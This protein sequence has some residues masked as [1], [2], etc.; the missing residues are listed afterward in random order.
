MKTENVCFLV[1]EQLK[2][3]ALK[4]FNGEDVFIL[5]DEGENSAVIY[6]GTEEDAREEYANYLEGQD[7]KRTKSKKNVQSFEEWAPENLTEVSGIDNGEQRDGYIVLTD[8]E[9]DERAKSEIEQSLWAFNA[10]FIIGEC[11]LD[12]SGAEALRIMQEKAC[13]DANDFIRSL[14][15]KC[16]DID[17]FV[18][19]AISS[20]GRG[21]FI[22]SYDGNENE[23]HISGTD[24]EQESTFYIYRI[25]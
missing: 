12:L 20:D 17:S 1:V 7:G 3:L 23:E 16:T 21:H 10:D 14:I 8:E 2:A 22:T 13:E 5:A 24:N 4:Q 19:S 15:D 18:D 9:A 25:D 11:G 6:E